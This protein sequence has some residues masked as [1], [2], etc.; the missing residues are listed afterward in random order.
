M[1]ITGFVLTHR[2]EALSMGD[3]NKYRA[4]LTRRLHTLNKRLGRTTPKNKKFSSKAAITSSDIAKDQG[5]VRI[6]LL[7]AERAWA[8]AMHMRSVHSQDTSKKGMV[9]SAR[10][11]IISRLTKST[12]YAKQLASALQNQQESGASRTDTLEAHAYLATLMTTCWMERR[13]WENCLKQASLA[14]VLYA[15]LE[16]QDKQGN[17]QEVI[18]GTVDPSIRYSAYQLKIPRSVPLSTI[19]KKYFPTDSPLRGE[20]E[21]IDPHCL[22]ED[23]AEGGPNAAAGSGDGQTFPQTITWRSRTVKIEDSAISQALA[24]AASA[25]AQL[26][27]WIAKQGGQKAS[28]KET[29]ANYDNV[30][31]ASQDAVDATKAAID[32]LTSEGTDQGDARMQSLQIT[33]TAVNYRLVGWRV[34][35]NRVLC[36]DADGLNFTPPAAVRRKGKEED[37]AETSKQESLG[38]RISRLREHVVLYDSILQSLESVKELPGVAAD[39]AFVRELEA[40]LSYFKS[41]RC[42]AIGRSY[43]FKSESKNALALF[44][45]AGELVSKA[46]PSCSE[47]TEA[48][49]HPLGVDVTRSQAEELHV[50]LEHLVWQYRGI[51]E[52]EKLAAESDQRDPATLPP[53]VRR[54]QEYH[55]DGVDLSNLVAYPPRLEPIPV[56]PIFLD[57]AWNYI[58][59]PMEKK[60]GILSDTAGATS[61]VGAEPAP[62]AEPK[63]ETKK[64]WFGF[65]R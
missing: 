15:A 63:K 22:S 47:E 5:Y 4:M 49:S 45:R 24:S 58:Q 41:L 44:I 16:K 34:G 19:A 48:S 21:A 32:E 56:K 57:L 2:A 35:R 64:G 11:H 28:A 23:T 20:V 10:R 51:V 42:L 9:G 26:A 37:G 65:G 25:E 55:P 3:Y 62:S 53:V 13:Q 60:K 61:A 27:G 12:V 40:K 17:I 50:Q 36:G 7:S 29:A 43:A 18:S 8:E 59:Y 33:K 54:M 46:L 38:R 30:I 1:D 52:I 31:I 6:L 39:A 14:R